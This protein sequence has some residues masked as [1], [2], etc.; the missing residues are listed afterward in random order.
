MRWHAETA[1]EAL[2]LAFRA[3]RERL[4]LSAADVAH[5]VGCSQSS[6]SRIELGQVSLDL[7]DAVRAGASVDNL[8]ADAVVIAARDGIAW[9]GTRTSSSTE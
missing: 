6:V 3:W 9:P 5:R 1:Q 8:L 4:G 7:L 2:G